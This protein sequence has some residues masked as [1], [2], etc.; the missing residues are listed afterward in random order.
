[1]ADT[2]GFTSRY[3][4]TDSARTER[5]GR[6]VIDDGLER[7]T[8]SSRIVSQARS[9]RD[10]GMNANDR[11][12]SPT[13]NESTIDPVVSRM[14]KLNT[15]DREA[16]DNE[17]TT[18]PKEEE[19]EEESSRKAAKKDRG[20]AQSSRK[21]A[22]RKNLREKRR[23]TGVVIMPGQ[24]IAPADEEERQVQENT[25]KN[26]DDGE[27]PA[28]VVSSVRTPVSRSESS[29][30]MAKQ[31]EAY[32]QAIEEWKDAYEKAIKEIDALR[33]DNMRLKDENSA[34]LRVVGSLSG[35]GGGS[36]RHR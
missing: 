13:N 35:T 4:K 10:K 6:R 28:A 18:K 30:E 33:N 23:S 36:G 25:V 22:A 2:S 31:L 8:D 21:R 11:I 26:T 1:M 27:D 15:T 29:V 3:R 32:E 9:G 34:L 12:E 17:D 24:Q 20:G 14:N 5:R 16:S 19:N 7:S